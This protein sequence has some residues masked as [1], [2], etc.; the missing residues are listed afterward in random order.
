MTQEVAPS[1]YSAE[2]LEKVAALLL[3]LQG[4]GIKAKFTK[5]ER[6]PVVTGYYLTPDFAQPIAKIA[7]HEEDFALAVK[8]DAV[9]IVRELGNIIIFVPNKERRL[10]DFKD[11]LTWMF[12]S[13]VVQAMDLPLML[14]VDY[15]GEKAALDLTEQPHVLLA[16]QTGSGKSVLQSAFISSLVLL[17]SPEELDLYLVDTKKLDLPLFAGLPHIKGIVTELLDFNQTITKILTETR[18]RMD[19][20]SNVG[21]RN[22]KEFNAMN[23]NKKMK[24]IVVVIDELADLIDQDKMWRKANPQDAKDTPT[25][26]LFLKA[27]VQIG[28]AAGVH[29][30]TG[31]QR[32]SVS[33][34][35]NDIK[36]NLP[37][38]IALRLPTRDDSKTILGTVG[39]ESLLGKGDMLIQTTGSD[40]LK[41][42]HGPFVRQEDIIETVHN[43][44][45]IR[46]MMRSQFNKK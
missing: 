26:G 12:S 24:Y 6:G 30:I 4:L 42:Y 13:P 43:H 7:K 17:K 40:V 3:K 38:R 25:I 34:I 22:I 21:V 8:V 18:K 36:A 23:F 27:L 2:E 44:E 15:L 10:I 14:G 35:S 45:F 32:S 37:C 41:R 16:G 33:I 20:L 28:R 29:V 46:Q 5:L 1:T 31:T 9:T 39:A 11:A 19:T